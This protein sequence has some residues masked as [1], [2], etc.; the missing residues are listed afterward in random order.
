M[1]PLPAVWRKTLLLSFLS[2]HWLFSLWARETS[3]ANRSILYSRKGWLQVFVWKLEA[4]YDGP[5]VR[6]KMCKVL[7]FLILRSHVLNTKRTLKKERIYSNQFHHQCSFSF[8]LIS[9]P[10]IW[11]LDW[12]EI[13]AREEKD[14]DLPWVIEA[15]I[16]F[17]VAEDWKQR[18]MLTWVS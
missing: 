15:S 4:P 14:S 7:R 9:F 16:L 8:L 13:E 1:R 6:R 10:E 17:K 12:A 5:L 18:K 3:S 11:K 2:S